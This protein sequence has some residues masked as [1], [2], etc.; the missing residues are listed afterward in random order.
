MVDST[1]GPDRL[2]ALETGP[3]PADTVGVEGLLLNDL[4]VRYAQY[5]LALTGPFDPVRTLTLTGDVLHS[6][7]TIL[8]A[9]RQTSEDCS[10][11][12]GKAVQ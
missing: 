7:R 5:R 9:S 1:N 10:V 6:V 2:P 8:I 3:L 11:N 4:A 12:P